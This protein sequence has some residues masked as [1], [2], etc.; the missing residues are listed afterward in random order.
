MLIKGV[1]LV[2]VLRLDDALRQAQ[3]VDTES[4]PEEA[5]SET[6]EL[7]SLGSSVP[8]MGEEFKTTDLS[9]TRIDSSHSSTSSDST[10]PL[11]PDHP[12][13]HVS[14]TPTPTYASFYRKTSCMTVRVQ[15]AM[16]LGYSARVIAAMDL[17][18]SA[19]HKSEGDELVDEDDESSDADDEREREKGE[20]V[21]PEGQRQSVPVVETTASK[22]LGLGYG[23]LRRCKLEVKEDQVPSSFEVGQ[24]SKSVLERQGAERVSMFRQLT[25]GTW[26]DLEDE[27]VYT[28]ISSYVPPALP[29]QTPPSPEWSLCSLLVLPSSPVVL[30]PI[31]SLIA[32]SIATISVDEDQFIEVGAQLELYGSIL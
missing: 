26:M 20:E 19:F 24:I 5:P 3:L 15:P 23:A 27:R 14:P 22:P 32:T 13:T 12:L 9:G 30:L 18:D 1:P 17:S 29:V 8:I 6:E 10:T 16:S 4:E 2:D 31:A 11:S 21:V 7:H 28:D 25:F